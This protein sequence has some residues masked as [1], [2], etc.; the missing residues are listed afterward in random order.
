MQGRLSQK[1]NLPLQSFPFNTW[2]NEFYRAKTIGF[3]KIEWLVDKEF[4]YKNPLFTVEGR[5]KILSLSKVHQINVET[6]C[7]HF[8][9]T[10]SILK[11]KKEGELIKNYFFEVIKQA[12]NIGIKFISI[13]L[14]EKM[15]LKDEEVNRKMENLLKEIIQK[16]KISILLESD[17]SNIKTFLFIK[18]LKS[19]KIGMLYD[20]GNA[21]KFNFS[22]KDDFPVIEKSVKEIHIKDFSLSLNQSVRL[23]E[24]DTNF[25]E[26]FQVI[27]QHN[28]KG[29]IVLET[30]IFANWS[31]EAQKNYIYSMKYLKDYYIEL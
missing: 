2:E 30:P 26:T 9:I 8:L 10:G 24:G 13:P 31:K 18:K 28:W 6:L 14:M 5:D 29:P 7:A 27:G 11:D 19:E 1:N 4:D 12:I 17:I 20:L 3:N 25:E 23:G 21:T 22:F 15:S 16:F